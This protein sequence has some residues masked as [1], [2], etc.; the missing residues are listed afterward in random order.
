[1]VQPLAAA[2]RKTTAMKTDTPTATTHTEQPKEPTKRAPRINFDRRSIVSILLLLALLQVAALFTTSAVKL[3]VFGGWMNLGPFATLLPVSFETTLLVAT[4]AAFVFRARGETKHAKYAWLVLGIFTATSAIINLL[5]NSVH[6]PATQEM[7][8]SIFSPLLPIGSL[9]TIHLVALIAQ[10]SQAHESSLVRLVRTEAESG[11][12]RTNREHRTKR[13]LELTAEGL[14]PT[15]ISKLGV[16]AT[17][18]IREA[19]ARA[20]IQQNGVT[21]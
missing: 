12:L 7:L 16:G 1:M 3:L 15:A 4:L 5:A 21:S 17:A 11:L 18:T 14:S 20:A 19:V 2:P 8:G 10:E 9:L 6:D 13:I